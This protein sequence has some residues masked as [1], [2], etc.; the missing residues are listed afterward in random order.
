MI[1]KAYITTC[2]MLLLSLLVASPLLAQPPAN[3]NCLNA[4][5]IAI[6]AGGYGYGLFGSSVVNMT[7][8]T[9]QSGETFPAGVP[10]SKSIWFKFSLPTTR[11][12][13]IILRQSGAPTLNPTDGGWVLYRTQ[14]CVP[15]ASQIVNPPI[16]N[17]EGFTHECLRAGDYL[18]QVGTDLAVAGNLSIDLDVK[19]VNP[20]AAANPYDYAAAPYD[21]QI[22]SGTTLSPPRFNHF[23]DVGCHSI[24]NGEERCGNPG[25][26]KS[27]WHVFNTDS[28]VDYFRFEVG[29]NPWASSV[30]TARNW[31]YNLYE[32]DCRVDSLNLPMV[33][34][35]KTLTQVSA[36]S[37]GACVYACAL[38]PNT[39][40]SVQLVH[41]TEYFARINT[42]VYEI[43]ANATLSPNPSSVPASHQFGNLVSGVP[44]SLTDYFACNGRTSQNNC[45]T[46]VPDTVLQGGTIY[47]LN[48][49]L[50]FN[51]PIPGNVAFNFNAL[52]CGPTPFIRV[53]NG[54]SMVSGCNLPLD[55]TFSGNFTYNCMPAGSYSIQVL[56]QINASQVLSNPCLSN[57]ADGM[58]VTVTFSQPAAQLFGLH[59]P[60]EIQNVN[61]M[62]AL[63]SGQTYTTALDYFDCRTTPMPNG[64]PCTGNNRAMYR[65]FVLAVPGTLTVTGSSFFHQYS[66]F[67]GN[68]GTAPIVGNLIQGLTSVSA[69][70]AGMGSFSLCLQPGT[71]TLV[72][73]GNNGDVGNPDQPSIAFRALTEDFGLF[74]PL[75]F[76]NLNGGAPLASGTTYNAVRDT[77]D[78]RS[79]RLPVA[80]CGGD[81][82]MY[83]EFTTNQT[84]YVTLGNGDFYLGYRL[85]RGGADTAAVSGNQILNLVPVSPCV[86]LW[87]STW[88]ECLPPGRYTL[89]TYGN[90][91]DNG[92]T[93]RP[94]VR[95][96]VFTE[97]YGLRSPGQFN[98]LNALNPLVTGVPYSGISDTFDCAITPLPG[99]PC[100]GSDRAMYRTFTINSSGILNISA[101]NLHGHRLYLGDAS[102]AAIVGN[103]VQGLA[104]VTGC[105]G[106]STSLCITPGR[107]TLVTFGSVGSTG[108]ADQVIVTVTAVTA[109]NFDLD[110]PTRIDGINTGLALVSGTTY[111]ATA[112]V[113]DCQST[114]L[115]AGDKCGGGNDRAI[116]R[117][118]T[119][120]QD[121]ILVV[122]GGD[123][124]RF[125]Y[126]LY[127]GDARSLPIVAGEIQGL[128]D[129][130][131]CQSTYY[132]FKVCVSP[133]IY[134]LVTFGDPSDQ[135][136]GDAPWL[137]FQTF[138]PTAY[139]NPA[140]PEVIANLNITTPS[141]SAT[142]T[143]F[144][145]QDNPLTI[146]G[147][148]P[149]NG[150]TKQV[151]RE[152]FLDRDYCL[153]FADQS[154]AWYTP[155]SG[156]L[157]RIFRGRISLGTLTGLARDCGGNFTQCLAA[158]WYTVV[159]YGFG[160]TYSSPT[161]TTG[162]GA[163]L[164]EETWFTLTI[165]TNLQRFGTFA[166]ADDVNGGAPI[167]WAPNILAGHTAQI[168]VNYRTYNLATE[169]WDCANN[170]PFPAGITGCQASYNRVSYR[171]FTLSKPSY[172][173]IHN[174]NPFPGGYQSRLYGGD[175]TALAPPYTVVHPCIT[176]QLRICLSPGTYTLATF[177]GDMH[178]KNSIS[179]SIY[180]DSL[181]VPKY[182]NAAQAYNFGTI[183]ANNTTYLQNLS[184][185]LDALGRPQS[186]DFF[187][188]GTGAR[189]SDPLSVCPVGDLPPGNALPQPTN[190]RRNLWYT[191]VVGGGGDVHVTV[192]N[193]TPGKGTQS[194]FA[195]YKSSNLAIPPVDSTLAQGLTL[196]GQSNYYYYCYNSNTVTFT[197]NNCIAGSDRYY[198]LVDN[199]PVNESNTQINVGI[200]YDPG[201]GAAV[202]YDHYSQANVI[203]TAG[204]PVCAP[205]YV[206]TP[207]STGTYTGCVADLTCAT[208]DP[209]DQAPCGTHTVWYKFDV[210]SPGRIRMNW[211][212]PTGSVL[213]NN[214]DMR[215]FRAIVPGDSSSSGLLPVPLTS[216]FLNGNPDFDSTNYYTWGQGCVYPGTYYILFTGCSNST[217]TVV[218]RI[219]LTPT[220]GDF[221]SDSIH[222]SLPDTGSYQASGRVDCWTIGEA[223]GEDGS[224]MDCL[225]GPAGL[226]SGW[227]HIA[228][229]DTNTMDLD[230]ELDENTSASALQVRYRVGVGFCG[231]MTYDECVDEG[232]FIIL[233]LK[234][235]QDSGIWVQVVVPEGDT[236]TVTLRIRATLSVDSAC[237]PRNP[238]APTASFDFTG[239]C[240]GTPVT[241]TN[242][243]TAGAG[244][245]Y[246]WDFGDGFTSTLATPTHL[247]TAP[248]SGTFTITLIVDNGVARDTA[249]RLLTLYPRPNPGF[250]YT[251]AQPI[252]GGPILLTNTTSNAQAGATF[253][254]S[255]CAGGGPCSASLPTFAGQNP[256]PVT[257]LTTGPKVICLTVT[258]GGCDS[259][260]CDTLD[261]DL[262]NFFVGGPYDGHAEAVLNA[263]CQANVF[264]GGPYDGHD[265]DNTAPC[266]TA[267]IYAGGPYDGHDQFTV[268]D[269]CLIMTAIWQGGPYDGAAQL[270][271]FACPIPQTLW[272]GG[273]FDGFAVLEST[274][275]PVG[276]VFAGGPYDGHDRDGSNTC[277]SSNIF[278]GG[279]Y[280]GHDRDNTAP[281]PTANIFAGGPFDGFD[282]GMQRDIAVQEDTICIGG[283]GVLVANSPTNW[284]ANAI[285]GAALA[286]NTTTFTTPVLSQT[287]LYW[288][289]NLCTGGARVPVQVCVLDSVDPQA[290]LSINCAGLPSFFNNQTLVAGPS[291]PSFGFNINGLSNP[292]GL[293]PGPQQLSFSTQQTV[294]FGM[295]SDG[296][297]DGNQAWTANNG[298]AATSWAQ[299]VYLTPKS[300][301]RF[302]YW[303][304][305]NPG[306]ADRAPK[307]VR[308]YASNGGPW[309][310]I[311]VFF[312][313]SPSNGIYDSGLILPTST[314][315]AT[316]WK[317]EFDSDQANGPRFGEF[318]VFASDPVVGG[319]VTWNFGDGNSSSLASTSH[320]Y[321][322]AG[323]FNVTMTVN[324][325]GAC[326]ATR[327]TPVVVPDCGILE[328]ENQLLSG[329][330]REN[331]SDIQLQW[332]ILG[333]FDHARFQKF[334]GGRWTDITGS[335]PSGDSVYHHIDSDV[336][337]NE[338]N[339]YRV[340]ARDVNG[341]ELFSNTVVLTPQ[342]IAALSMQ[343]FPNPVSDGQ[344]TLRIDVPASQHIEARLIDLYGRTVRELA[345]DDYASGIHDITI[346]TDG[347]TAGTYFVQV[348]HNGERH[349]IKLVVWR[350]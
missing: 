304:D 232:T 236:G 286:T 291:T 309:Q 258:N 128:V 24:F 169:Y 55:T 228:I 139:T 165:D 264:V 242:N 19:P 89:V 261:V 38:K 278:A 308:L 325:P 117:Y 350:D 126:R 14:A 33:D 46:I 266:P 21:F 322:T 99:T 312:P 94:Y 153:T 127:R 283:T 61:G 82:A 149:C 8:A 318:Q 215:L 271:S 62:T 44:R 172:V 16:Q 160:E 267:N 130:A 156:I 294:N 235:R 348:I 124:T 339:V 247:Y 138:P 292:N 297:H 180:L 344:A 187:F 81:R 57:L 255:F 289:E 303:N 328:I 268:R 305:F 150:A 129:Q 158:G 349:A 211:T 95:F 110:T 243:S 254:W 221:C 218:P 270:D 231:A 273:P 307:Q 22:V 265:R 79:T 122:G 48:F 28:W 96:D 205:P 3:D 249:Q 207:L 167:E 314:V 301:N 181:G 272:R 154:S 80:A 34:S 98:E 47:D 223:S 195:V 7:N 233:N 27:T 146:L 189:T 199:D 256:P 279:P 210:G 157:H 112:D 141:V 185:S 306:F 36:T 159:T 162:L 71:Y 324:V 133:G 12:V 118:I 9:L 277:T 342:R 111:N 290:A 35:C 91:S 11:E 284:Y 282:V 299:W 343:V 13:R 186:N 105:F 202:L 262:I 104:P 40:Y 176:D 66:V 298:A 239:G 26:T 178:I 136:L 248:A 275:C 10:N 316:R 332:D 87:S 212:G 197:R 73:Y 313:P 238:Y 246:L 346:P 320:T 336:L 227:F 225:G 63:A 188:C 134:T 274:G 296:V 323:T 113:F 52:D 201:G 259:T 2:W 18:L 173:Y 75:Q 15:G 155:F 250:T 31:Y 29:E 59:V 163:S 148:A 192:N 194:P 37:Y 204:I 245:S 191:F 65:R 72:T 76:D 83:R 6:S 276:N 317:L 97:A 54:N 84:G 56:G 108:Q 251:P 74:T 41:P 208:L 203:D 42:R 257:Y 144:N 135:G 64:S 43:G 329:Q 32:G 234:C 222:V 327:V 123:W 302:Y 183:P 330:F 335:L 45:G 319:N 253:Y 216:M 116:Y 217:E 132:P 177:A 68:A 164:G 53:F 86:S 193:L 77:F 287:R 230:I 337:W 321:L 295:L 58:G 20:N 92:R 143:R 4:Q 269:S 200:R 30:P 152:F 175:I 333:T 102:T 114:V 121:G 109:Q 240:E 213:W 142:P 168:P 1:A 140:A 241:F 206:G 229:S 237:I 331:T 190:P 174:L 224:N 93:D 345:K 214:N 161:Y 300:V 179:P 147:Y 70:H 39:T 115:P 125:N 100:P 293:P 151:Y 88:S 69:C 17:I 310:L 263:N 49:W 131:N 260:Y 198:I 315:F 219:W 341:Q 166:T 311:K 184:H 340:V 78:C 119:I 60:A 106:S 171:V 103:V 5:N 120:G 90:A 25:Y 280:D 51:V 137:H 85:Y 170:L 288:V 220:I 67:Q 196:V 285:G 338:D 145:C 252:A 182:D 326:P 209:D 23:F 281:C 226:K 50:T 334:M 101:S 107:Y 244:V 347:I